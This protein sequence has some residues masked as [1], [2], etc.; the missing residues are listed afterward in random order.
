M[1]TV[2]EVVI[3][4]ADGTKNRP[5]FTR[6]PDSLSSKLQGD[7]TITKKINKRNNL[8]QTCFEMVRLWAYGILWTIVVEQTVN[9]CFMISRIVRRVYTM[10]GVLVELSALWLSVMNHYSIENKKTNHSV[11]SIIHW[12]KEK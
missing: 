1:R 9:M 2:N 3:G 5:S 6:A 8:L 4:S 10:Y 7:G 11:W 12:I